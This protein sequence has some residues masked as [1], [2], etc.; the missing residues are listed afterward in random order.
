MIKDKI[1][2]IDLKKYAH[3]KYLLFIPVY[4]LIFMLEEKYITHGYFVSYLPLDRSIRFCEWFLIPYL[5]WYPLMLGTG[6]Y[7]FAKDVEGFKKYMQLVG[8]GFLAIVL[9]Y[10][11]FPNGQNL[12]PVYFPRDN[13]LIDAVKL[14]YARDTNTNVLPSLHVFGTLAAVLAILKCDRLR[15]RWFRTFIIVLSVFICMS[16]VYIK[17]HSI[18]DVFTGVPLACV[19]YCIIYRLIPNRGRSLAAGQNAAHI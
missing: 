15:D 9:F 13:I 7:L 1:R 4:M 2:A 10:A 16:T 6:L 11:V 8:C 17:Q 5:L 19:F 18:L 12:R 3:A 14:L